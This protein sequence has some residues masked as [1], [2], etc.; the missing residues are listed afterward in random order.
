MKQQVTW[1]YAVVTALAANGVENRFDRIIFSSKTLC[2]LSTETAFIT[3]LPVP[4]QVHNNNKRLN[5]I[6]HTK[7][8]Q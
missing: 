2:S 4:V 5:N 1:G 7:K 8:G 3:V 6:N